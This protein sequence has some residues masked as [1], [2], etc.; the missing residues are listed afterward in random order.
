MSNLTDALRLQLDQIQSLHATLAALTAEHAELQRAHSDA[1]AH[2]AARM[3]EMEALL[4]TRNQQNA[5]AFGECDR[6]R[7]LATFGER[8]LDAFQDY[9]SDLDG[10]WVQDTAVECGVLVEVTATEPC[11]P[12]HCECAGMTD[13]PT[14]CY[15]RAP[16]IADAATSPE[17]Q[18]AGRLI[19]SFPSIRKGSP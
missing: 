2:Y 15:R 3:G 5:V 13:F 8:C 18:E 11:D 10:G 4:A 19:A 9:Y 12:E 17:L 16:D 7:K 6:L 1:A 14:K